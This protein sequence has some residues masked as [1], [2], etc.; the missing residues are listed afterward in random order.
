MQYFLG[1]YLEK[2]VRINVSQIWISVTA[3]L[4][5]LKWNENYKNY[6]THFWII[7]QFENLENH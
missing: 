5:Y 1:I 4:F 3:M 7:M 6:V 2:N